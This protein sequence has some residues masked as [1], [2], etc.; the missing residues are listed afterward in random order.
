M[1]HSHSLTKTN[2]TEHIGSG[3]GPT[4]KRHLYVM[5]ALLYKQWLEEIYRIPPMDFVAFLN[6]CIREPRPNGT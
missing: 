1:G 3:T 5:R 6:E 2:Y 4:I